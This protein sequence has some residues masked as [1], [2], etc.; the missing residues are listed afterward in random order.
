MKA[1]LKKVEAARTAAGD[2]SAHHHSP[3]EVEANLDILRSA[4]LELPSAPSAR[5]KRKTDI[6]LCQLLQDY[7]DAKLLSAVAVN[8]CYELKELIQ[9]SDYDIS[10]K[11][12][13]TESVQGKIEV[14][15]EELEKL[16]AHLQD[17]EA[18][19]E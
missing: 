17:R 12:E 4:L 1:N 9:I 14:L 6:E 18:K 13:F 3:R 2:L 19:E 11:E 16:F 10:D 8:C 7:T 5:R 15:Q